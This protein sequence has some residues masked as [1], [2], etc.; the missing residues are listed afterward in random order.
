M[1][2]DW[3]SCVTGVVSYC[4]VPRSLAEPRGPGNTLPDRQ[5]YIWKKLARSCS[6]HHGYAHTGGPCDPQMRPTVHAAKLGKSRGPIRQYVHL[7]HDV[8]FPAFSNPTYS[9]GVEGR[10][11][12]KRRLTPVGLMRRWRDGDP[13]ALPPPGLDGGSEARRL[14]VSI[15]YFTRHITNNILFNYLPLFFLIL[16]SY[17]D[18]LGY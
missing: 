9:I 7:R 5:A 3:R 11:H 15:H 17:E 6:R 1:E 4:H 10:G 8:S 18:K 12:G 16:C 13:A 2:N 14:S